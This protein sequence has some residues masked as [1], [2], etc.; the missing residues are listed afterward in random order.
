MGSLATLSPPLH[1]CFSH[2]CPKTRICDFVT[3]LGSS[4]DSLVAETTVTAV[5]PWGVVHQRI[6][7]SRHDTLCETLG[8]KAR[9]LS[10]FGPLH[11]CLSFFISSVWNMSAYIEPAT[12]VR[13]M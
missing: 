1:S 2:Y 8:Y 7:L 4:E 6:L 13:S 5:S 11:S 3:P 10:S 9:F 12:T